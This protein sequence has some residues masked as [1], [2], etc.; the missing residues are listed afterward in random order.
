[1]RIESTI[2][3]DATGEQNA[4]GWGGEGREE[5]AEASNELKFG[6]GEQRDGGSS[7]RIKENV[8]ETHLGGWGAGRCSQVI[9]AGELR[10]KPSSGPKWDCCC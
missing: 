1:M 9:A 5:T 8:G 4:K 3:R 10:H 6:A 7:T 2:S